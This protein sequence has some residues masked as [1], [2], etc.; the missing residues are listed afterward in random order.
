MEKVKEV[1]R[2]NVLFNV[3]DI[4]GN[5]HEECRVTEV[6][7]NTVAIL[8]IDRHTSWIVHKKDLGLEMEAPNPKNWANS[9]FDLATTKTL[10]I[11][12]G[13]NHRFEKRKARKL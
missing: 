9:H 11:D 3:V 13:I 2:G 5:Q 7:R 1:K 6:Y 12:G 4:F 10:G 8:D